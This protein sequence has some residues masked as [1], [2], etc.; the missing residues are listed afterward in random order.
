MSSMRKK[1]VSTTNR[2][3]ILFVLESPIVVVVRCAQWRQKPRQNKKRLTEW[4]E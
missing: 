2:M 1:I 3:T 4:N